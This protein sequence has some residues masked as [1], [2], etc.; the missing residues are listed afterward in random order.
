MDDWRDE[1]E[2]GPGSRVESVV[3]VVRIGTVVARSEDTVF[4]TWDE[5][6]GKE[7]AEVAIEIVRLAASILDQLASASFDAA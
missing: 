1:F 4:V 6:A 3:G 2:I 7:P 5:W